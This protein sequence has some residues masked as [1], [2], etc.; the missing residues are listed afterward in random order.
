MRLCKY[1][2]VQIYRHKSQLLKSGVCICIY[3][4]MDTALC[5]MLVL[6]LVFVP[7]FDVSIMLY[8]LYVYVY[9]LYPCG[10]LT[11]WCDVLCLECGVL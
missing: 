8:F 6:A 4:Y 9:I 1:V 3:M 11:P 2:C 10:M 7:V 5:C